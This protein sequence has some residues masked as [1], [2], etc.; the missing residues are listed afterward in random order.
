VVLLS[1]TATPVIS[2][3]GSA[4]LTDG[5]F[6]DDRGYIFNYQAASFSVDQTRNTA[7]LIRLAP[8]VSNAI[9][10]DLGD[11][12]LINRAQLLL[13][14]IEFTATGGS[15]S[16]GVIIEGILNPQNY[17][18]DPNNIT[19]AGLSN[20]AAGGQPSFAQIAPGTSVTWTGPANSFTATNGPFTQNYRTSFVYF[21]SSTVAGVK[22]GQ[23]VSGT[24]VP[25]GTTVSRIY[26]NFN[27]GGQQVRAIGFSQSVNNPGPAGTTTYTFTEPTSAA[28]PGETV[29]SFIGSG[30]GGNTAGL[31]LTSLK[32]LNNTPIGGRGTFPN[33]PDVLAINVYTTSG[34]AFTGNLVLRWSEAQA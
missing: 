26:N 33:G 15:S 25:G 17:P 3:W 2:H 20:A 32:E 21:V 14:G 31:D 30:G 23:Q 13:Q 18:D 12:E 22:V 29:F 19:W 8:S 28:N 24:G 6:D 9:I 34:N 4:F 27:Y 5:L 11:R 16:Q 7:F 1:N 10:G